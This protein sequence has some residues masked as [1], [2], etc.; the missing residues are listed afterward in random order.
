M[1]LDIFPLVSAKRGPRWAALSA[2]ALGYPWANGWSPTPF[3]E[4]G[5]ARAR[6]LKYRVG[7]APDVI[8]RRWDA[9]RDPRNQSAELGVSRP[10]TSAGCRPTVPVRAAVGGLHPQKR[11]GAGR[12]SVAW[13]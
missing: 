3:C 13:R 1:L 9:G 7:Q 2:D 10:S 11:I 6:S 5:G 8:G 12:R 4:V